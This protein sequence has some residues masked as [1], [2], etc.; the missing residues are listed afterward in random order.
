MID[1]AAGY[2]V[3][4]L[5]Q[6][7]YPRWEQLVRT[8]PQGTLFHTPLWLGATGTPFRLYGCF[9]GEELRAGLAV[10]L[11]AP[12]VAGHPAIG[13]TPYLG[14][15]LP[16]R[17]GKRVTMLSVN[18]EVGVEIA[19]FLRT[20]FASVQLRLP[21]EAGDVQPFLWQGFRVGVRYTY[22]LVLDDLKSVEA[23][24]DATRR[25]NLRRA[26]KCGLH[27]EVGAPFE[28]VLELCAKTFSRQSMA[29]GF[30]ESAR[31]IEAVLAPL[32]RCCGFV[33]RDA[34]RRGLAA[35]WTV[36]DEKRAYYLIGG[37]D[38]A[39]NSST[40]GVLAMWTAIQHTA[41]ELRLSEFDF[42]GSMVPAIERFFRMF[43][44]EL[45]PTYTLSW[46]QQLSWLQSVHGRL[47]RMLRRAQ[48][49]WAVR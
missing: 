27:V 14:L 23:G 25:R 21:P 16:T 37:Y 1:G 10:G 20:E 32:G 43:G 39:G 8:S 33:V 40:A 36:W 2:R 7:E 18:K 22:R 41:S 19:R 44:G 31:G 48:S 42:E 4:L 5:E 9:R 49:T 29:P 47:Q 24:M 11:L 28:A 35:I 17:T 6:A 3:R 45:L 30:L 13:L 15:L 26:E 34:A 46:E 12:G 38:D